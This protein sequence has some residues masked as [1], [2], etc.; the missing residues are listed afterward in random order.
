MNAYLLTAALVLQA[1]KADFS[2][3]AGS[4]SSAASALSSA[5]NGWS[6][7]DGINGALPIQATY[8]PA[9]SSAVGALSGDV[10]SLSASDVDV[11][12]VTSFAGAVT[13]LLKA[14]SD[15]ASD[16]S[17]AGVSTL[18]T[19]DVKE[20]TGPSGDIVNGIVKALGGDCDKID[21]LTS[22]LEQ[23]SSGFGEL[24]SAYSVSA[25]S[26]ASPSC[27]GGSGS[28]SSSSAAGSSSATSAASS[29]SESSSAPSPSAS[30]SSGS[31]P[32]I[33]NG[34]GRAAALGLTGVAVG[35]A[36]LL[37]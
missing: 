32:A 35:A 30:S 29:S 20:I 24:A 27:S 28:S 9:L 3:D 31:A 33:S 10:G 18:V 14:L 23:V 2:G 4:V 25:P 12:T 1:A 15:K 22:V 19:K 26:F 36:A 5:V 6:E 7:S 21:S 11:S 17:S 8:F 16:F 34:A 37:I 13:S